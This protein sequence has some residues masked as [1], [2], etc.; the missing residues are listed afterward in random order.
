MCLQTQVFLELPLEEGAGNPSQILENSASKGFSASSCCHF[1]SVRTLE[2][3]KCLFLLLSIAIFL[4][5]VDKRFEYFCVLPDC[6]HI[7]KYQPVME[8]AILVTLQKCF[9]IVNS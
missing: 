8:H 7:P 3:L 2:E 9:P 4:L 1:T 6:V 5:N